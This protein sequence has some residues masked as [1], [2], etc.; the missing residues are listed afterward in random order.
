MTDL[1]DQS[2]VDKLSA[3]GKKR[4]TAR[5]NVLRTIMSTTEGRQYM[6][7]ELSDAGVFTQAIAFGTAGAQQLYF[8]EGKRSRGLKLLT[9]LTVHFP[10]MYVRM[11]RENSGINLEDQEQ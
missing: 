1:G 9:E 5:K 8:T 2:Q 3:Q 10:E 11:Q 4:A 7:D 6:W